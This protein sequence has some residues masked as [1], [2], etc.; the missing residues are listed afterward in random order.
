MAEYIYGRN[1]VLEKLKSGQEMEQLILQK[2]TNTSQFEALAKDKNIAVRIAERNVLDKLVQGNHQGVIGVVKEYRYYDV[3]E[4][5]NAIPAGK[6]PLL[7]M[8]DGLEDPHNLGAV[9]RTCDALQ[10]DGVII[11]KHRSVGLT[12]TVAKVSTGAIEHIKVAQVTNLR[13]TLDELK[14]K[15][16]WVVGAD[17]HNASDYRSLAYDAPIVLVVGSEGKGISRIVLDACD[18]KVSLPMRGHV[19]SLNASVAAAIL[20]YQ[21]DSKRNP[22]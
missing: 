1:T 7:V 2:G 15:G 4:I 17:H 8:L 19:T 22:L 12:G 20:L 3:A 13:K 16:Y 9:L 21:I 5:V 11:G 14:E 18:F 6:L 10:V